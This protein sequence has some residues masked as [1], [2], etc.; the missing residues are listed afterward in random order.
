MYPK[1]K[2]ISR[3]HQERLLGDA[4]ARAR[5]AGEDAPVAIHREAAT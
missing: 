3:S 4:P 1:G 2:P 5:R